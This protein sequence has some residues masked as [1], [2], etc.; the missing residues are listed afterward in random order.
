MAE[1]DRSARIAQQIENT[2]DYYPPATYSGTSFG[3]EQVSLSYLTYYNELSLNSDALANQFVPISTV[4]QHSKNPKLFAIGVIPPSANITGRIIDR[5]SSANGLVVDDTIALDAMSSDN[6]RGLSGSALPLEFW[7]DY[8]QMCQRLG[9]DPNEMAAVIN[10]ESGFDPAAVAIRNGKPVA[11]GLN[12]VIKKN[13]EAVGLA[14]GEWEGFEN[15]SAREQLPAVEAYFGKCGVRGQDRINIYAKNFGGYSNPNG[16]RY[17]SLAFINAYQPESDRSRFP[18][19][20]YQDACYKQN[21]GLDKDGKGFITTAD[22]GRNAAN[23]PPAAIRARIEEAQTFLKTGKPSATPVTS[24]A[25]AD[26]FQAEGSSSA[27]EARQIQEKTANTPLSSEDIANQFT[28]A[29][30][31]QITVLQKA[32]EAMQNVPPLRMLVNPS[33]FSVKGEKIVADSG[34]SRNGNSIIEHW[35]NQQEKV[36]ASGKV[37]GFYAID[38]RNAVGPGLTR[39]A[40]NY[41]QAW[42]NFQSLCLF[43][44]NNAGLHTADVTTTHE[45]RNLAMLGSVYL[46]Y[47][48]ILYIGSF[49]SLSVSESETTPHTVDYSFEFTVRA[50]FLLDNPNPNDTGTYGSVQQSNAKPVTSSAFF[51]R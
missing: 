29:Q 38:I 40:R 13:S 33:S 22:L 51:N 10:A 47:D 20:D 7:V 5:T 46:F 15:R 44:S 31:A 16:S 36:S 19:P 30:R 41:S 2:A 4:P 39:M 8:V 1:Q 26:K 32:L 28:A 50:A 48:D 23:G 25:N 14:P 9:V 27:S 21:S 3:F 35:G 45:E 17:A 6:S 11:K 37:A 49:D 24:D 34:W 42:Q 12:Q 43:Y 18:Q